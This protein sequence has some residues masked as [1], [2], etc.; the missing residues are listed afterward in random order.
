MKLRQTFEQLF[1]IFSF[2]KCLEILTVADE[3]RKRL[4]SIQQH[5]DG[6]SQTESSAA[7]SAPIGLLLEREEGRKGRRGALGLRG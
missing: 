5:S 7:P 3:K 2:F 6:E 4:F 1:G